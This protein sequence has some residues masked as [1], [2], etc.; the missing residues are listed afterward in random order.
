VGGVIEL[1]KFR[2]ND[3]TSVDE[4]VAINAKYQTEFVYQQQGL[5]RRTVAPGLNGQWIA[6]TVW[7]SKSDVHR[8][9]DAATHSKVANEFAGCVEPSSKTVE[10]FQ[11][12]PG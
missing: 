6:I 8:A 10:Y 5:R 3:T 7:G 1:M 2:L 9:Q 11:E 4:F 12:L